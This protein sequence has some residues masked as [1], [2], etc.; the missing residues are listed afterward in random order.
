MRVVSA[1]QLCSSG[2]VNAFGSAALLASVA[3]EPVNES[4]G[5]SAGTEMLGPL[6][7]AKNS[8]ATHTMRF[9]EKQSIP[10]LPP[11]GNS[12]FQ[13]LAAVFP[14]IEKMQK[15]A[16]TRMKDIHLIEGAGHWVQQEQPDEVNRLL[17][18]FL[19]EQ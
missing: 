5:R 8:A 16:C 14:T 2:L 3:L 13:L 11:G 6:E 7:Q 19:K 4:S 17:L 18:K 15:A 10:A 1:A 9:I 12:M